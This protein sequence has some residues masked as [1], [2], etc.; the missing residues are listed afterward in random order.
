MYFSIRIPT[1]RTC[2]DI[3]MSWIS[4]HSNSYFRVRDNSLM[5]LS[6]HTNNFLE[7]DSFCFSHSFTKQYCILTCRTFHSLARSYLLNLVLSVTDNMGWKH[8]FF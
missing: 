2:Q 5:G 7:K 4:Q 8:Y 1:D 3:L 6:F